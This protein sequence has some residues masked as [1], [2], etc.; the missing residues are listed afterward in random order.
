MNKINLNFEKIAIEKQDQYIERLRLCS[1]PASDYSFINIWGWA[2]EYGLSWAWT[3]DL[4][5]IK[6][7]IPDIIYW[8]P[9]GKWNEVNWDKYINNLKEYNTFIRVPKS[10]VNIWKNVFNDSILEEDLRGHWDY[11]YSINDLTELK[12][13]KFHKKK[14][15][16]NQFKKK[17]KYQYVPFKEDIIK[18]NI[19]EEVVALQEDWC[20]WRDCE[21]D[22]TLASENRAILKILKSWNKLKNLYG[23]VIRVD[24][25]I[26]AYTVGEKLNNDTIIIHFEK[27]CPLY[28]GIYQAINQMFLENSPN[29]FQLVNREQDL[30]DEGLRKAKL[31]YHPVDFFQKFK[32]TII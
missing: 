5:W 30:D 11:L 27:G 15:L 10:L 13:N 8:A 7:T 1:C 16:L 31:S 9:V 4:I 29:F 19:S 14:N 28:K 25:M 3:D 6:Q 22:D 12:G 23:G 2:E 26:V 18:E 20:T 17:Y 32:V 24:N 21:S